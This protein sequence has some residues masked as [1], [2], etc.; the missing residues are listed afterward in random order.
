[1]S[2][3]DFPDPQQQDYNA[4]SFG[5]VQP[6]PQKRGGGGRTVLLLVLGCGGGSVLL[7]C[8]CC[9]AL[10]ALGL[11]QPV[12]AVTFWGTAI[13]SGSYDLALNAV[14]EGSQAEQETNR[15]ESQ[16]ATF[17]SFSTFQEGTG[18]EVEITAVVEIDG[19]SRDY[20]AVAT[21]QSDGGILGNCITTIRQTP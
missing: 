21:T 10:L 11:R 5:N 1:M 13:Q 4:S 20:N 8:V 18:N 9:I 7:C 14:C 15:L 3:F 17:T 2:N 6:Q 19:Q 12:G 16:G